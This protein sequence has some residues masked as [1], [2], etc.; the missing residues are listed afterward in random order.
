MVD[1]MTQSLKSTDTPVA[2]KTLS[3]STNRK[4]NVQ[5]PTPDKKKRGKARKDSARSRGTPGAGKHLKRPTVAEDDDR[6]DKADK[7][8]KV[9][10]STPAPSRRTRAQRSS[11]ASSRSKSVKA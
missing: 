6:T 4:V 2:N 9:V 10:E 5:A 1:T 3:D 11:A 8:D 7:T